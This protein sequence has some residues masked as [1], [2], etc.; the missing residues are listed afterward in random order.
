MRIVSVIV[1]AD[2]RVS[3]TNVGHSFQCRDVLGYLATLWRTA[4]VF[5]T[6]SR[7]QE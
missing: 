4:S 3:R 7:V 6:A 5:W 1:D 2:M